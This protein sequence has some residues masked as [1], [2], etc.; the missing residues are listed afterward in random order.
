M[1]V[2]PAPGPCFLPRRAAPAAL[3]AR[4]G[5][6][7]PPAAA[8]CGER[9]RVPGTLA[10]GTRCSSGCP[11]E[12]CGRMRA[13]NRAARSPG[14]A[15]PAA[16]PCQDH[17]VGHLQHHVWSALRGDEH[18]SPLG[19]RVQFVVEG[20]A[21]GRH[22]E[23]GQRDATWPDPVHGP[24]VDGSGSRHPI[25][26][27]TPASSLPAPPGLQEVLD[28]LRVPSQGLTGLLTRSPR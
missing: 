26:P 1:R 13:R 19:L 27:W 18:V 14:L 22:L 15:V 3:G 10:P 7:P 11:G 24:R 2:P 6:S 23:A 28:T 17:P 12:A 20:P 25:P 4:D 21:V 9:G 16:R 5:C 8:P